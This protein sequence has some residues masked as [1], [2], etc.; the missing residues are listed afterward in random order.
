MTLRNTAFKT[1]L[2]ILS[3]SK[4][5][6]LLAGYGG[7]VGAILMLHHVRDKPAGRFAPNSH[8]TI[9]PQFL[10]DTLK[11]LRQRNIDIVDLDQAAR[12]LA[13]K[14]T[15]RQ[16][17]VITFDDG[18]R[19]NAEIAAPV[20][21]K[22]E[23]PYT[24]FVATGLIEGTA[25]LWWDALEAIIRSQPVLR[26]KI[27]GQEKSF[28][29]ETVSGKTQTYNH[30]LHYLTTRV[31]EEEQSCWIREL[32][33][34]YGYDLERERHRDM[35][36]WQEIRALAKDPLCT[37]GA[38]TIHHYALARLSE[39]DA[40][41]EIDEGAR[42]IETE[43][44]SLPRHFAYPYGYSAA[45]GPREFEIARKLSFASAVT[46]RPGVLYPAHANH[47][48]ALPRI[49]LNGNFQANH[50]TRTLL[51]GIPTLL[52]NRMRRINVD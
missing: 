51:S 31:S 7:G 47:L 10:E 17:V 11:M 38:H 34:L 39:N 9:G 42:I 19:N 45:A 3:I 29:S 40:R 36:N 35:M 44:G 13:D 22:Y 2:N 12:R 43:L 16:F 48:T 28:A 33:R 18:Y 26:V 27:D 14:P 30:L 41:I 15:D 50:Y 24:I 5:P 49:S 8:L 21:R 20:L 6:S 46:T 23:A 37:I 25:D 1:A 52:A 4:L 32:A